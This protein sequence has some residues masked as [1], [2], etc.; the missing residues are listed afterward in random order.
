MPDIKKSLYNIALGTQ[1][2]LLSSR[3][4]RGV[5]YRPARTMVQAPV[6]GNRFA[7]GDR[8]YTDFT[9]W[10]YWAQTDWSNG[11]KDEPSWK[12]DAKYYL[13]TNIDAWFE[14]GAIKLTRAPQLVNT[15]T[16][17]LYCGGE[18]TVGGT[19]T[20]Y[21]GTDDAA[22][23]KPIV[24]ALINGTWTD[25]SSASMPTMENLISQMSARNNVL[26]VS[27][28]GSEGPGFAVATYDG[29]TWLG[30]SSIFYPLLTYDPLSSRCHTEYAGA[31]YVFVDNYLN[32]QYALLKTTATNPSSVGEWT[33]V[34]ERI[35]Q[36]VC[37]VDCTVYGE[38]LYYLLNTGELRV[39]DGI[40]NPTSDALV[41]KFN[42]IDTEPNGLGGKLLKVFNG[43]LV[44]T[45]PKEEIWEYDGSTMK[46]IFRRDEYKTN[47]LFLILSEEARQS[48]DGGCVESGG[49]LFWGNLVYDGSVFYN[50]WKD[51]SDV[52]Y[53]RLKMLFTDSSGN[54]YHTDSLN[55][56]KLYNFNLY[57]TNYK[58]TAGKNYLIFNRIDTIST[59]NKL[60][61]SC[62]IVFKK[63]ATGQKI[64]VEY[65][66]DDMENW[67]ELGNVSYT[68]DGGNITTKTFY[69]P[70]NFIQKKIWLRAKLES[71]GS[72]T[73]TLQDISIV[74]YPLPEY[75]HR[76]DLTI[77]CYDNLLLLD[78]KTKEPKRGEELR[79][80]LKTYWKDKKIVEFQDVDYAQTQLNGA[81]DSSSTTITVDDTSK[82]PEQGI[83]RIE[84]EKI[85]YYS[86]TAT[87]FI[88]TD[89]ST[90]GRGYEGTVA[91][92]HADKTEVSNSYKVIIINYEELTP[93]GAES[94]VDEF[95]VSLQLMEV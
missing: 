35:G 75:K 70:E 4:K 14:Y 43:K 69:F 18:F 44:I 82:F 1:G 42:K 5:F 83:I 54:I 31:M 23:G 40:S 64:A 2:F 62:T 84:N 25:I 89:G 12:D 39:Y 63:L 37:V 22:S 77:Q 33:K 19:T 93:L 72:D 78:G 50:G 53:S 92:S 21:V 38:K 87:A 8:N 76:W 16:E 20:K 71:G 27:C 45:I 61:Y 9:F 86:K 26:W 65:S 68:N 60:F 57:G 85:R 73:P 6:F 59:I 47:E 15:F 3:D 11:F 58:G 55:T 52:N 95:L 80:I 66:T 28:V 17:N 24:Y 49:K 67:T 74:Y 79:N 91:T 81:L 51:A 32:K 88:A 56:K 30:Q 7:S 46:R 48:L 34:F 90:S 13:S 94:K 29:T 41:Y 36:F 10:W